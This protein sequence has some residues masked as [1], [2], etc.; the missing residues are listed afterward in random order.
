MLIWPLANSAS[1]MMPIVFWASLAPCENAMNAGRDGLQA[2]E[3]AVHRRQRSLA[4]EPDEAGHEQPGADEAEHRREPT[5]G[6]MIL[7]TTP[8]QRTPDTPTAAIIAP[9]RPP[10]SAWDEL[11]GMPKYQVV[12]FH[13]TAPTSG[14][15]HERQA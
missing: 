3:P 6:R 13:T 1:V 15:E 14:R 12:K 2:A 8:L 5:M 11:D 9:M 4:H 7:S 10:N